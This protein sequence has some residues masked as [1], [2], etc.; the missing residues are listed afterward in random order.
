MSVDS[1]V[2]EASEWRISG[3]WPFAILMTRTHPPR[4]RALGDD[5]AARR[6]MGERHRGRTVFPLKVSRGDYA[7]CRG[8]A[9]AFGIEGAM[10][11]DLV[12]P[13]FFPIAMLRFRRLMTSPVCWAAT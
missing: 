2:V 1:A 13:P 8:F 3:S 7:H 5:P 6:Y 4:G 11:G 9:L 12:L 10:D